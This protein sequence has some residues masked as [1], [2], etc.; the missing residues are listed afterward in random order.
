MK[1]SNLDLLPVSELASYLSAFKEGT[2]WNQMSEVTAALT[3]SLWQPGS[4]A[5][6]CTVSLRSF[7]SFTSSGPAVKG[8]FANSPVMLF[9]ELWPLRGQ[10]KG[11]QK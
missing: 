7:C 11:S 6:I 9:G 4:A 1:Q 3:R 2:E 8:L 5:P 10:W